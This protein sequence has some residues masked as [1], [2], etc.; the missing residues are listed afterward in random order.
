MKPITL[1]ALGAMLVNGVQAQINFSTNNTA[2][3]NKISRLTKFEKTVYKKDFLNILKVKGK[4][5]KGTSFKITESFTDELGITHTRYK[6]LHNGVEIPHSMIILH[7]KNGKAISYNGSLI[8]NYTP[9]RSSSHNSQPTHNCFPENNPTTQSISKNTISNHITR[10]TL[11]QGTA[12]TKYS[13]TQD[14]ETGMEG[15][16]YV[17]YDETRG[18]GIETRDLRYQYSSTQIE[19][20]TNFTSYPFNDLDNHWNNF[21]SDYDE[22]ATDVH[23]GAEKTYDFYLQKLNRNSVDNQ[24]AKLE[25]YVHMSNAGA[26]WA[27]RTHEKA[28]FGYSSVGH[29]TSVD[30]VGH[31]FSHGVVAF[32]ADLFFNGESGA[33]NE[34]I[35]DMLGKSVEYFAKPNDFSWVVGSDAGLNIRDLSNPKAYQNPD[36]YKGTNWGTSIHT[37][38]GPA[39][40]WFYLLSEGG[41]GTNDNNDNYNVAQIGIEKA[42]KIAYRALSVYLT[43]TSDYD[44][45]RASTI[46]ATKDLFGECSDE[47][48]S[49]VEGWYA[50]GVGGQFNSGIANASFTADDLNGCTEPHTVNF[51]NTSDHAGTSAWDFGDGAVSSDHSPSHTYLAK[52]TYSVTLTIDGTCGTS[53]EDKMDYVVVDPN[54]PCIKNM[55][56]SQHTITNACSGTLYDDGGPNQ[57]HS[58]NNSGVYTI[59]GPPGSNIAINFKSFGVDCNWNNVFIHDGASRMAPKVGDY[60]NGRKP[61]INQEMVSSGNAITIHFFAWSSNADEGFELEWYCQNVTGEESVEVSTLNTYPNPFTNVLTIEGIDREVNIQIINSLGQVVISDYAQTN[62]QISTQNLTPGMYTLSVQGNNI[63]YKNSIIKR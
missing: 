50:V 13:G 58:L 63:D 36:T 61:P 60:C 24:G 8:S 20:A 38:S 4:F 5:P 45:M 62:H 49:V 3:N 40:Y 26:F 17:L 10:K 48:E 31:E 29:Y 28:F 56:A 46:Q 11:L 27:G 35:C 25:G 57:N 51:T 55:K 32:T 43:P 44:D 22:V 19:N 18:G 14:I 23:W 1:I 59:Q 7:S 37:N 15:D 47:M 33:L 41:N 30:I 6:Q 42:I 54:Q 2:S 52:G 9:T 16:G 53:V 39:G 12:E 34:G 21:N